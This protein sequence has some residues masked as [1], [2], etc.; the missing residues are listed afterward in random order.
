LTNFW[1]NATGNSSQGLWDA[2]SYLHTQFEDL[3]AKGV[4]GY[5]YIY[6]TSMRAAFL[7][8]GPA[9]GE[10][11]ARA[12]W[13]PVLTK[14]ASYPDVS[15]ARVEYVLYNNYKAYFDARFGALDKPHKTGRKVRRH[16]PGSGMD[17][18]PE[19]QGISPLD[20]RLLG[21]EHFKHPNLTQILMSAAPTVGGKNSAGLQG[22]LVGGG[23]AA[24]PDD[25]TS[26]LPAWRKALVH[27]IGVKTSTNPGVESLRKLAPESGAY[28]NEVSLNAQPFSTDS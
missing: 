3:S 7:T 20:S 27:M 18:A 21:A 12:I 22:H 24:H 11:K 28:A 23:K 5:Y 9:S 1:F 8:A 13:E 14:M 25:D 16:G 6:P 4:S 2:Y 26:V 15:K 17:K 10:A 19:P